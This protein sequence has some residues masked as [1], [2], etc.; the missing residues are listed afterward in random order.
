MIEDIYIDINSDVGEGF[1]NEEA[2]MPLLSSCNIA[3]GAHAGDNQ[4]ITRVAKLAKINNVKVGAHPSYPDRI[5][6]G[7]KS[8]N[9]T[10]NELI[11]SVKEQMETFSS[12]IKEQNIKLHHI[13]PHGALYNDMLNNVGLTTIFLKA[14]ES[15]KENVYLFA[16]YGSVFANVAHKN[17]FS[18]ILEAFADRN[19]N[20]DLSLVSRKDAKAL[21]NKP[22]LVLKHIISIV[23]EKRI[24]T[25]KGVKVPIEA[26]TFCIHSDTPN[27]LEILVY[28]TDQ[29][30]NN[31]IYIN[32]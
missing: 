7:R 26:K 20:D 13:K 6:F 28:L 23:K 17:K 11:S 18:V 4:T 14:I 22:S 15:Y 31:N 8:L 10:S 21:I 9:L 27:A 24:E 25:Y 12:L 32:K 3:C 5:N 19:Y 16:P 1:N 2:L 30:P 29:L